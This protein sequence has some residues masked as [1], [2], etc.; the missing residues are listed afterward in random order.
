MI[1]ISIY[2]NKGECLTDQLQINTKLCKDLVEYIDYGIDNIS[3]M[4][5][6]VKYNTVVRNAYKTNN[7]KGSYELNVNLPEMISCAVL[8]PAHYGEN[9][10]STL[11]TN[12]NNGESTA[13]SRVIEND[14]SSATA[15]TEHDNSISNWNFS[16]IKNVTDFWLVFNSR[17]DYC[18]NIA[19]LQY[20]L[21]EIIKYMDATCFSN[22][23]QE[24]D[25]KSND[26]LI[27]RKLIEDHKLHYGNKNDDW[28][29]KADIGC[30]ANGGL[31]MNELGA[32]NERLDR[33]AVPDAIS[34][35]MDIKNVHSRSAD[36]TVFIGEEEIEKDGKELAEEGLGCDL[37]CECDVTYDVYLNQLHK[38]FTHCMNE[39]GS[40]RKRHDG[41]NSAISY[42]TGNPSVVTECENGPKGFH[43]YYKVST[44][45]YI[46]VVC[47]F[48][49]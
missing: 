25:S 13:I 14:T 1:H 31:V 21:S 42:I 2:H 27:I 8:T 45:W 12:T 22:V 15:L 40:V 38:I 49:V 36:M 28:M 19:C 10:V 39:E 18:D 16:N 7:M 46:F 41:S 26:L 43:V 5:D 48:R 11:G 3:M 4:R 9:T 20:N 29:N 30:E 34:Q 37:S 32:V 35:S 17:Q 23:A 6:L 24:N 47:L 44:I 33:V